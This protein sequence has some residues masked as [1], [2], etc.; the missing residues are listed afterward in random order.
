MYIVLTVVRSVAK[1]LASWLLILLVRIP[2][3]A[4][5]FVWTKA[6]TLRRVD[7]LIKQACRPGSY[8]NDVTAV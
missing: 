6:E 7:H 5:M 2:L 4:W 3:R 1:V 8:S